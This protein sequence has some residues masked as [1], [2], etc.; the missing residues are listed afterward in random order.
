MNMARERNARRKRSQEK[1]MRMQNHVKT[2]AMPGQKAARAGNLNGKR[3]QKKMGKA[4]TRH[5]VPKERRVNRMGREEK[6]MSREH[7]LKEK[8]CQKIGMPRASTESG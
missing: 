1:T 6:R 2:K 3:F 8:R 4:D 7:D 5:I